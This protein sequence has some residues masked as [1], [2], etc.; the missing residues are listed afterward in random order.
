MIALALALAFGIVTGYRVWQDVLPILA[1][2][3]A[4]AEARWIPTPPPS[5][6]PITDLSLPPDVEQLAAGE[7]EPWARDQV[8]ERARELFKACDHD[9]DRAKAILFAERQHAIFG[10]DPPGGVS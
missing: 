9:W 4:V 5:D 3:T 7:S 2:L 8:R 10:G 6:E 1:R